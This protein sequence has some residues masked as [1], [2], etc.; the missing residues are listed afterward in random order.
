MAKML[1]MLYTLCG[2]GGRGSSTYHL[3]IL[4]PA[5]SKQ[6]CLTIIQRKLDG[7]DL[8][9]TDLVSKETWSSLSMT[10]HSTLWRFSIIKT[11]LS[12]DCLEVFVRMNSG[13]MGLS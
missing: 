5:A 4:P 13:T 1:G 8:S 2:E 7:K 3:I 10:Y 6:E 11:F 12:I 9:P